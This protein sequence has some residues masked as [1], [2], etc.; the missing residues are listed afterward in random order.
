MSI[1]WNRLIPTQRIISY[2]FSI[3]IR[4]RTINSIIRRHWWSL[5]SIK[6][7]QKK[8]KKERFQLIFLFL[9]SL[10]I[11]AKEQN[12]ERMIGQRGKRNFRRG[13]TVIPFSCVGR[14]F[15]WLRRC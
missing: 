10:F 3:I 13:R 11:R 5:V 1:F 8:K 15:R 9:F 14:K 2:Q 7:R 6:L 12:G 4:S